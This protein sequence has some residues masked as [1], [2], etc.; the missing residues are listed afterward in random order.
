MLN[1][2]MI[3]HDIL[4]AS[5]LEVLRLTRCLRLTMRYRAYTTVR[6]ALQGSALR[7][8]GPILEILAADWN[9]EKP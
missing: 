7:A 1:P 3:Q 9:T 8:G 6:G 4:G 5:R 2:P